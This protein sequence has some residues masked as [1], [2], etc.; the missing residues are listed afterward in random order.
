M[1]TGERTEA[2]GGRAAGVAVPPPKKKPRNRNLVVALLFLFPALILLGALVL[3]PIFFTTGRSLY[4]RVGDTFVGLDNYRNMFSRPSTL[5]AMRNN[6]IWVLV[7]PIV[8]TTLGLIF[9]VLTERVKWG[10]AFKVVVFMPMAIAFLSTGVIWRLVY[11]QEPDR[12]LAN[13][14]IGAAVNTVRSP[15]TYPG[16]RAFD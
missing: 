8:A 7:A 10:T 4:D 1:A 13:A 16:A 15:G 5:T 3:Y 2:V 12:G 9:A 6:V 11:Q 14:I